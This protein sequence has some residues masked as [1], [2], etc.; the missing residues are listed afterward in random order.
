MSRRR[1][2]CNECDLFPLDQL[3]CRTSRETIKQNDAGAEQESLDQDEKSPIQADR[4]IDQKYLGFGVVFI[5]RSSNRQAAT[6]VLNECKT[7][8]GLPVVPE[9][10]AMR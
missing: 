6:V 3:Q 8:F 10:K 7:H 9:V 2:A 1:G 4:Q 5:S